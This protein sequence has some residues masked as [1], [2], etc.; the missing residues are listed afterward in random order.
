MEE[1]REGS[2]SGKVLV[3]SRGGTFD[4]ALLGAKELMT[5]GLCGVG[6]NE[7]E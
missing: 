5:G 3:P 2:D 6:T 7:L 4:G 1:V